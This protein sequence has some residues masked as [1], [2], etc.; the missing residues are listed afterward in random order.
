[1]YIHL[2]QALNWNMLSLYRIPILDV[3]SFPN[4]CALWLRTLMRFKACVTCIQI[5]TKRSFKAFRTLSHASENMAYFAIFPSMSW[6]F[7][8]FLAFSFSSRL[9]CHMWSLPR[10]H[11]CRVFSFPFGISICMCSGS[12]CERGHPQCE[13]AS[14]PLQNLS[15]TLE[16]R[17][18]TNAAVVKPWPSVFSS[19]SRH[20]LRLIPAA[21]SFSELACG[22]IYTRWHS[23]RSDHYVTGI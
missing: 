12:G 8:K 18:Q 5:Y 10:Q 21:L 11:F 3:R 9:V 22:F 13:I 4:T 20:R 14:V 16:V 15:F 6:D 23:V 1:M 2:T 17:R 19:H 7:C